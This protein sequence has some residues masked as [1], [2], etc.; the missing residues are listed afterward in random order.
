MSEGNNAVQERERTGFGVVLSKGASSQGRQSLQS[1]HS[2]IYRE[3]CKRGRSSYWV[4]VSPFTSSHP[5]LRVSR[6]FSVQVPRFPAASPL[7]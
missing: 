7:I 1:K 4:S 5:L 6:V 3:E 2:E